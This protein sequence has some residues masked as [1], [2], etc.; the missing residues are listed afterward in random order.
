MIYSQSDTGGPVLD[1]DTNTFRLIV[2]GVVNS[3]SKGCQTP[4]G[5]AGAV[6]VAKFSDWIA[7]TILANS[8]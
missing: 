2:I 4:S 5:Y 1:L 8:G 3:Y 6:Q 7:S